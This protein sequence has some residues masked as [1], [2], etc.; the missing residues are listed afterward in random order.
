MLGGSIPS[1]VERLVFEICEA[2][3]SGLWPLPKERATIS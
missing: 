2:R 3:H 1:R